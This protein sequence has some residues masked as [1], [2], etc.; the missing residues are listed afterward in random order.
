MLVCLVDEVIVDRKF[1]SLGYQI[2]V[3][4]HGSWIA[5]KAQTLE[6]IVSLSKNPGNLR[7]LDVGRRN[8]A[9]FRIP[10]IGVPLRRDLGRPADGE[11]SAPSMETL[12]IRSVLETKG[13]PE[14][15]YSDRSRI[16]VD[17]GTT[18]A[19]KVSCTLTKKS[20]M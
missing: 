15:A 19:G 10:M 18:V 11:R 14:L 12:S 7:N 3:E 4:F 5:V 9:Q 16:W 2:K 17:L 13:V 1:R 20:T 6:R 8:D